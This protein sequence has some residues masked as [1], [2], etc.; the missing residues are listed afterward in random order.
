MINSQ[1]KPKASARNF[2]HFTASTP[3]LSV[4]PIV[5]Y[6]TIP[7]RM[8]FTYSYSDMK[9]KLGTSVGKLTLNLSQRL[10]EPGFVKCFLEVKTELGR[11]LQTRINAIVEAVLSEIN[12]ISG[13]KQALIGTACYKGSFC[14]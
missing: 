5:L 3:S 6:N 14:S 7:E 8:D 4:E 1:V 11:L 9:N 10:N 2:G 13:T 12:S